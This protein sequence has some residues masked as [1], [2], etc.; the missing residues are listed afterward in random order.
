MILIMSDEGPKEL[1]VLREDYRQ[2]VT[3]EVVQAFTTLQRACVHMA[4]ADFY[5]SLRSYSS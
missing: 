5:D 2:Q 3:G 4:A 1:V